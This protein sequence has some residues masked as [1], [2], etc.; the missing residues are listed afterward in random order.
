MAELTIWT[1]VIDDDNRWGSIRTSVHRSRPECQLELRGL[2]GT[3]DEAVLAAH[4]RVG[5]VL[6]ESHRL[7]VDHG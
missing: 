4:Y 1:L 5:A 7:E 6:I 2:Y 3:D